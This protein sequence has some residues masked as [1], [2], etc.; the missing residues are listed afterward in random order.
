MTDPL[1]S[2]SELAAR[3]AN[4]D[5]RIVDGTWVLGEGASLA[6]FLARRLPGAAPFDLDA[7][8]DRASALPHMLPTPETF[9]RAVGELGIAETDDIVVYDA[10]GLFSSAR[11]WWTFRTMGA[12]RVRVL[13]GGLPAWMALGLPLETGPWTPRPAARFTPVFNAEAVVGFETVRDAPRAG[14]QVIDARAAARFRGDAAEP[15]PGMRSGHMPG[16]LNLP[17]PDLLNPDG[18]LRAGQDLARVF[19]EAGVD[20]DRPTITTCGSGVTAAILTLGLER[21]GR[22]SRLYDGSWAEWGARPDT[23]VETGAP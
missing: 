1:I 2:A 21:L 5:L 9:A 8:S 16:A 22:P 11:V 6:A 13:D 23:A 7:V 18:T 12:R 15:R 10:Q 14:V 17:Y 19:A 3:L 4:A 20:I